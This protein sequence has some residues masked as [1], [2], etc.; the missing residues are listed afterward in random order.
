MGGSSRNTTP[1]LVLVMAFAAIALAQQTTTP[2]S[3]GAAATAPANPAPPQ[4]AAA[5]PV[6]P[7][8][9]NVEGTAAALKVKSRLVVVDVIA[10]DHKGIPVAD[11]KADDFS[12]QEENKPQKIRVFN[13]QQGPQGQSAVMTPAM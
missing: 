4:A 5:N 6:A 3:G 7:Q 11:F 9:E 10:L 8:S 13:F 2:T 1:L 12:L